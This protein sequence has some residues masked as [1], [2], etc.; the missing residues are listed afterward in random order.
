MKPKPPPKLFGILHDYGAAKYSIVL[1]AGGRQRFTGI[2]AKCPLEADKIATEWN[3]DVR[4]E[5][6]KWEA[7][8]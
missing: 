8:K 4:R 1:L 5:F 3:E 7:A 2:S 6:E